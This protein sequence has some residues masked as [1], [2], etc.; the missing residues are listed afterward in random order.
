MQHLLIPTA[1]VP[2]SRFLYSVNLKYAASTVKSLLLYFRQAH[3]I[4]EGHELVVVK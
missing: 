2:E 1:A 3:N 4:S